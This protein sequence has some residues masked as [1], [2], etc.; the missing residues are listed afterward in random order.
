MSCVGELEGL[1][2]ALV[3]GQ[4][5]LEL[6]DRLLGAAEREQRLA[7]TFVGGGGRG[8]LGRRGHTDGCDCPRITGERVLMLTERGLRLGN[9][10]MKLR[11]LDVHAAEDLDGDRQRALVGVDRA[12]VVANIKARDAPAR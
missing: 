3:H 4:R 5:E 1:V 6:G 8:V 7:P 9:V 12:A 10:G 11:D 2:A